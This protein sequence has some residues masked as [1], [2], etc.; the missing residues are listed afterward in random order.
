M[1]PF[2][3]PPRGQ[4]RE[5]LAA[6]PALIMQVDRAGRIVYIN[7]IFDGQDVS[8]VLSSQAVDWTAPASRQ[9]FLTALARVMAVPITL[10]VE[11]EGQGPGNTLRHYVLRLRGVW[12]N[13]QCEGAYIVASDQTER[14][15]AQ[16]ALRASEAQ[17]RSAAD[18]IPFP[19]WVRDAQMVVTLQNA[20][21]CA[22]WGD[23]L[24]KPLSA[25]PAP[26]EILALADAC[27]RRCLR[28]EIVEQ[29]IT[30]PTQQGERILQVIMAPVR[31]GD[32]IIGVAGVDIDITERRRM[33]A[34]LSRSAREE[35]VGRLAG[36][37]AHDFNNL[38]TAILGYA[39]LGLAH[40]LEPQRVTQALERIREAGR[41]GA[42]LTGQL[43]AYARHQPASLRPLNP[44]RLV[45]RVGRLIAPLLS[46]VVELR[47]ELD[48]HTPAMHADATMIEQVLVNVAVNARDAMP[49]GGALIIAARP[50]TLTAAE[51]AGHP[52]VVA[53]DFV[54]LEVRDCGS[55]MTPAVQARLFEPFFTTKPVG[56]GT[57]LGLA[58]C[59][60]LIRQHQGII[61]VT[62][63]VGQGTTVTVD[64][65]VAAEP[66]D[67]AESGLHPAMRGSGQTI[68]LVEDDAL[69][70][71]MV[72]SA[73]QALG[74]R[75]IVAVDGEDALARWHATTTH[76]DLLVTD[77]L[78][79][80]LGG[81]ALADRLHQERAD[82]RVLFMS[83]YSGEDDLE[84]R[85]PWA[86]FLAKPFTPGQLAASIRDLLL[87]W[88]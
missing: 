40:S 11:V 31:D 79:P 64:I 41:R 71:D 83:G 2:P 58:S 66:A 51:V 37:V 17:L 20:A 50:V 26:P 63:A 85:G 76:I 39:E 13:E 86:D 52:R 46:G 60:G 14:I 5:L 74:Y 47:L 4:L 57:G 3:D 49:D 24:G 35:S 70:R 75:V 77:L 87:R 81:H 1:P 62:S 88:R 55:G 48:P 67:E 25:I 80:R 21:S 15:E 32:H 22:N 34:H 28:G 61:R 69:I 18:S 10:D 54:R 44:L 45:E 72:A 23:L 33:E 30:T 29:E 6:V 59:L 73:L 27:M 36:G 8:A 9:T 7:Q 19:F 56:K 82:V 12:Q 68:L 78:M 53:G 84:D 43:L 16:R 42:A 38:L 65:P